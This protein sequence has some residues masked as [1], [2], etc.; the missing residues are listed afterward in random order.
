MSGIEAV[1]LFGEPVRDAHGALLGEAFLYPPFTVL[2]A[3]DGWWQERKRQWLA[4]GIR[5]ELGR[6]GTFA[7]GNQPASWQQDQ[8][9]L[10]WRADTGYYRDRAAPGGSHMPAADYSKSHARGAGNGKS[11]QDLS[12]SGTSV[13]DPVLT[14]ICYR[15]FCPPGGQILDPF[16]GGS[17]RG[18]VAGILGYRYA[19]IEL[20]EAQVAANYEQIHIAG[21][22]HGNILWINGDSQN[23]DDICAGTEADFVF[24]CPPYGGL[25]KYSDDPRDLSNM[26][27]DS[28]FA[29]YYR[30]ISSACSLLKQDRFAAVV[31]GD[32][33]DS[34][35]GYYTKFPW[36]TVEAF[37]WA[38]LELYNEA[39]LVTMVGSLPIRT[40]RQFSI[41]RKLGKTHQ[42]ILVFVKGD[43]RKA[44]EA[45]G[46]VTI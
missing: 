40:G 14:E 1:D 2:S 11:V 8:K 3:R 6:G 24:T 34:K 4:L 17:V 18:L 16:A 27:V 30:C 31:V 38:G 19:G 29:A 28:F 10:T 42:N 9:R 13:F 45:C 12:E 46:E 23:A 25:E 15:W 35:T 26:P 33:R 44:A 22:K 20:S 36:R 37:E 41:G 5:S 43:P 21:S 7:I 39:V 32:Y